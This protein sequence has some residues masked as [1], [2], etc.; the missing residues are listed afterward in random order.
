[1]VLIPCKPKSK[2]PSIPEWSKLTF[3]DTQ[4]LDYKLKLRQATNIAILLGEPSGGLCVIDVDD[5]QMATK[6]L[7]AD[8]D[9]AKTYQTRGKRGVAFWLFMDG[10]YPHK[11]IMYKNGQTEPLVEFRTDGGYQVI[12]G[13]HPDTDKPYVEICDH[14]KVE[15]RT[16]DSI[17][18]PKELTRVNGEEPPPNLVE[19][20]QGSALQE[21]L[22][23]GI[24]GLCLKWFPKGRKE[25]DDWVIASVKG[26]K[27]DSLHISLKKGNAG[28]WQD[29]ETSQ[30][31]GFLELLVQ[32]G[33]AKDRHAAFKLVE[34]ECEPEIELQESG[35]F[36]APMAEAAFYGL[37]GEFV[38]LV[39]PDT[40]ACKEALLMQFLTWFG[41]RVGHE[42]R[43][44]LGGWQHTNLFLGII[45]TSGRGAKGTSLEVVEDFAK[46]VDYN[47]WLERAHG[48][49]QSGESMVEKLANLKESK[50]ILV[51]EYELNR[52]FAVM[53]R[54]GTTF[55]QYLELMWDS[56]AM[57]THR[58]RDNHVCHEPHG[59]IIGHIQTDVARSSMKLS[60]RDSGLANRFLYC[61]SRRSKV[62]VFPKQIQWRDHVLVDRMKR[63]LQQ[64][65]GK[66][67]E[68]GIVIGWSK[69]GAH[70]YSQ[71]AQS[72]DSDNVFLARRRAQV[73]RL[74]M[75]YALLDG[76]REIGAEHIRAASAVWDY[77]VRTVKHVFGG[78]NAT[79][80]SAANKILFVLQQLERGKGINHRDIW[81]RVF[82][83]NGDKTTV[84]MALDELRKRGL[85]YCVK[86]E[87]TGGRPPIIWY[88]HRELT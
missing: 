18:W 45:G 35:D 70:A 38:N 15:R 53:S 59:S 48:G 7:M 17:K 50:S 78:V 68:F 2:K 40:E 20:E 82:N 43:I 33:W 16:F 60:L 11:R 41:S 52:L 36:P 77:K 75:L 85:A 24:E 86:G 1:V 12:C 34:E 25:G 57:A 13:I 5:D 23:D 65:E 4:Q 42:S 81:L 67:G 37:A 22:D 80:N 55:H 19:G 6:M 27:G 3:E 14:L 62:V 9:L 84:H 8:P 26:D 76:K 74:A 31:G 21:M 39:Y 49:H 87:S 51:I 61:A 47:W 88:A 46:S 63:V 54:M 58:I 72:G 44:D 66:P 79:D 71:F 83:N 30:K 56:K 28:V 29:F 32:R 10:D 73:T 69:S 64:F